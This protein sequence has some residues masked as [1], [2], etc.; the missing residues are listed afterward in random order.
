MVW[1]V[2]ALA[3]LEGIVAHFGICAVL[4]GAHAPSVFAGVATACAPNDSR[5]AVFLN[6]SAMLLTCFVTWAAIRYYAWRGQR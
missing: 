6:L 3:A 4:A 1:G 2:M 5:A